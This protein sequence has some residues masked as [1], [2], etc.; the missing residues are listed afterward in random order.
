M[1]LRKVVSVCAVLADFELAFRV[2][3]NLRQLREAVQEDSVGDKHQF[4]VRPMLSGNSNV[5]QNSRVE[6]RFAAK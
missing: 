6:Q 2:N 1:K 3:K 5:I 4:T